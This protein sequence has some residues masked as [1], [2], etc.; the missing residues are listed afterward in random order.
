MTELI[1]FTGGAVQRDTRRASRA[2]ERARLRTDITI[3][4][5]DAETDKE[6]AKADCVTTAAASS[7]TQVARVAQLQAQLETQ[8]PMAAQRLEMIANLHAHAECD[9]LIDLQRRVRRL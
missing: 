9:I 4:A 1:P 7:M 2:I 5:I 8:A 6:M 3:A